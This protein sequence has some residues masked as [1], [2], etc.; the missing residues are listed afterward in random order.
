M[1]KAVV[2]PLTIS[3]GIVLHH[4]Y[5]H[6]GDDW[7]SGGEKWFQVEDT[8]SHETWALFFG[9]CALTAHLIR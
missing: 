9:A 1:R 8:F 3:I 4:R 7:L 5:K 2:I 6:R